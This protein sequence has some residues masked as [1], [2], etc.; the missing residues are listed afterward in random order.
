MTEFGFIWSKTNWSD[1]PIKFHLIIWLDIVKVKIIESYKVD[2]FL[3][4]F[5]VYSSDAIHW[6]NALTDEGIRL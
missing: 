6:V 5:D 4:I 1:L 3:M 2:A